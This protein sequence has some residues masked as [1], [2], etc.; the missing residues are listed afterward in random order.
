[1]A[2]VLQ[3]GTYANMKIPSMAFEIL[4]DKGKPSERVGR[5]ATDLKVVGATHGGWA[6]EVGFQVPLPVI[7]TVGVC[8]LEVDFKSLKEVAKCLPT[9]HPR[10]GNFKTLMLELQDV[11]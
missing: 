9:A 6:A 10:D 4:T 11:F 3:V 7:A 1:M 2:W 8:R 5:K